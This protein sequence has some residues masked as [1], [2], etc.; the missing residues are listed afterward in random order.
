MNKT[1]QGDST[2]YNVDMSLAEDVQC[3]SC[4]GITFRSCFFIKKI[5]ALISPTGK[6]TIVPVESF[7]CNSCGHVNTQFMPTIIAEGKK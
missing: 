3:D 5:S 2:R 4:E 1:N 6:E 7:A